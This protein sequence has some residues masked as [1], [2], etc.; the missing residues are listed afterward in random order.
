MWL[1]NPLMIGVLLVLVAT[2]LIFVTFRVSGPGETGSAPQV[3]ATPGEQITTVK[4]GATMP[5][6]A[7]SAEASDKTAEEQALIAAEE[8]KKLEQ[9]ELEK[10]QSN[11]APYQF[12]CSVYASKTGKDG[13]LLMVTV[14]APPV[15][16]EVWAKITTDDGT[17]RG[18]IFL[19]EGSGQQVLN[20]RQNSAAKR[21]LIE[22]Y[23]LP[24]YDR[25]YKM[26]EFR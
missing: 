17:Q 22:I 14:T 19:Q 18:S 12:S 11:Q 1:K 3:I 9:Q 16:P 23:S 26:C 21:P 24:T 7:S 15:I 2:A 10:T 5:A 8:Q 13:K 20:L 6:P 25:Q 4:P